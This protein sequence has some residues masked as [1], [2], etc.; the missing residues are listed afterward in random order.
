MFL[1]SLQEINYI[2]FESIP[3]PLRRSTGCFRQTCPA[4]FGVDEEMCWGWMHDFQDAWLFSCDSGPSEIPH[5]TACELDLL[6]WNFNPAISCMASLRTQASRADQVSAPFKID[7]TAYWP[8]PYKLLFIYCFLFGFSGIDRV[9]AS[10]TRSSSSSRKRRMRQQRRTAC[11][12][13]PHFGER[14]KLSSVLGICTYRTA[15]C[16]TWNEAT[17]PRTASGGCTSSVQD[18]RSGISSQTTSWSLWREK[19]CTLRDS[20][21]LGIL[22]TSSCFWAASF[23]RWV[24]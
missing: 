17:R 22:G 16:F 4:F 1:N 12:T 20:K 5:S 18:S 11:S 23:K 24:K 3:G 15:R 7:G 9:R 10:V 13:H 21:L 2:L 6:F 19:L 8:L 14:W